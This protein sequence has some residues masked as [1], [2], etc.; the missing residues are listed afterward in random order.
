MV[1]RDTQRL[2]Q[3]GVQ[4]VDFPVPHGENGHAFVSGFDHRAA[5]VMV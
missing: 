2:A 3:R 1:Q 5:S 4:G